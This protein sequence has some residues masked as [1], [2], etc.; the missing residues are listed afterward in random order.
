MHQELF[1]TWK[2]IGREPEKNVICAVAKKAKNKVC[3]NY[4]LSGTNK[5]FLQEYYNDNGATLSSNLEYLAK[6][7][8]EAL[9]VRPDPT[10]ELVEEPPAPKEARKNLL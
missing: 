2:K 8:D 6:T 3:T 1:F 9:E 5:D 10:Y 4:V 7:Y